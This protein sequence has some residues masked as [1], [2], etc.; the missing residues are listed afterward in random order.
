MKTKIYTTAL[1]VLILSLIS[2]AL[3]QPSAGVKAGDWIEY[4]VTFTGTPSADHAI[5]AARMEIIDVS[6]PLIQVKIISTYNNGTQETTTSTLNLQTGQLID[7]FIIPAN[8]KTGD[9]FLDSRVG[10]IT[11][12]STEQ[13]TY[14]GA[15]R[16]VISAT[17]LENTY[18]WD[19]AT[20]ISVEGTSEG[21]D[22]TM[23]S[24][25]A[26]TN[27]WQASTLDPVIVYALIVLVAIIIAAI[28]VI[29]ILRRR[30]KAKV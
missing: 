20:G 6:G 13:R 2:L 9:Q 19:Q 22:Y 5:S 3:A 23:H 11:I 14:A 27:I 25:V 21:A 28:L 30:E 18:V 15:T 1:F 12:T 10:N 24:L 26:A 4:Q 17:S 16:T 7:D 29:A 8:L